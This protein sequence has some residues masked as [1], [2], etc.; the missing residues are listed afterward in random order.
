[1]PSPSHSSTVTPLGAARVLPECPG[2]GAG[3]VL[4]EVHRRVGFH[5]SGPLAAG[6]AAPASHDLPRPDVERR[7]AV[8]RQDAGAHVAV[9]PKHVVRSAVDVQHGHGLRAGAARVVDVARPRHARDGAKAGQAL[10]GHVVRHE[11]AVGV[12]DHV[13]RPK[14]LHRPRI[15]NELG[16]VG[17]VVQ[18]GLAALAADVGGVPEPAPVRA[19][20]PVGQQ[21]PEA[22]RR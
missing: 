15:R 22:R 17:D 11:P 19:L 4:V 6:V 9:E 10:A 3:H 14:V 18:A 21:Q 2:L 13:H 1:M 5:V 7:Y 8:L 12:A 20:R 16:Q